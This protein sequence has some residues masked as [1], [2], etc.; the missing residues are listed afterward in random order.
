MRHKQLIAEGMGGEPTKFLTLTMRRRD[1]MTAEAAAKKLSWAWRLCR[2]RL[3]RQYKLA[4]LPF[5]AVI[6]KHVSGWPHLHLLCRMPYIPQHVIS[7]IMRE[8][9]DGP[10]VWINNIDSHR[11]KAAYCAKYCGKCKEK[12][13]TAKRYWQSRDY[14]LRPAPEERPNAKPG[15]GWQMEPL[16]LRAILDMWRIFEWRI[17]IVSTKKAIAW[18]NERGPPP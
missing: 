3:M 13:G 6:E 1:D 17:E 4:A 14:D 18:T 8:L 16:S 7:A 12:I 2:L 5:L 9:V 15:E 10:N 11:R